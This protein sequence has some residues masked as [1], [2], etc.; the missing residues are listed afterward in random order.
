MDEESRK[1]ARAR[2]EA[3][4]ARLEMEGGKPAMVIRHPTGQVELERGEHISCQE[5]AEDLI[6]R[7]RPGAVLSMPEGWDIRPAPVGGLIEALCGLAWLLGLSGQE[8]HFVQHLA[9]NPGDGVGVSAFADWLEERGR[10]AE[11]A[12]MRRAVIQGGLM[13][14]AN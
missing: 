6:A 9:E 14:G 5:Y 12:R 4:L 2:L 1:L 8:L 11:A 3:L 10:D 7:M 13:A